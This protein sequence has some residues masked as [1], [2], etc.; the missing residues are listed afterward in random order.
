M[1]GWWCLVV[2]SF[3]WKPIPSAAR[4]T[5]DEVSGLKQRRGELS[6]RQYLAGVCSSHFFMFWYCLPDSF[7]CY[8]LYPE[9]SSQV[10][11][12]ALGIGF[13]PKLPTTYNQTPTQPIIIYFY[14]L[15]F[16]SQ[17]SDHKFWLEANTERSESNPG[18]SLGIKTKEGRAVWKTVPCWCML[19][20]FFYVLVLSS[21]QLFLLFFI[22]RDFVPGYSRCARYWLPAKATYNLQPNTNTT[23]HYIFL[24]IDILFSTIRP[25]VLSGR[26]YRA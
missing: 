25:Q 17:Q 11:L 14:L 9:T 16:Y 2:G 1:I 20:A 26:Q 12:A 13:Q 7:F 3:G 8:S 6:G 18:R 23:N 15:I 19:I 22:S 21:R 4:V 24:F 5:R 10:T